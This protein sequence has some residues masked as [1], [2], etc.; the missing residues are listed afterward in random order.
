MRNGSNRLGPSTATLAVSL[1]LTACNGDGGSGVDPNAPVISNIRVTFTRACNAGGL[2]GTGNVR[3]FDYTDA[4]GNLAG[5]IVESEVT[6]SSGTQIV[7]SAGI[8]SNFVRITGTTSGSVAVG[9]CTRFGSSTSLQQRYRVTDASGKA[10]NIT[11]ATI[12]RPLGAPLEPRSNGSS[13]G[14]VDRMH[15]P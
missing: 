10:S 1:L 13:G 9:R 12:S 14:S 3:T 6:F 5:G 2:P 8:P 7:D 4:D 11:E 15:T